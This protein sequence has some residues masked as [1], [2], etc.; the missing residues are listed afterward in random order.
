M[1]DNIIRHIL[2]Y[3]GTTRAVNH[4]LSG[5]GTPTGYEFIICV[6]LCGLTIAT[7][8]FVR[9]DEMFTKKKTTFARNLKRLLTSGNIVSEDLRDYRLDIN[10]LYR[11]TLIQS[12][13][14]SRVPNQRIIIARPLAVRMT[15]TSVAISVV[16]NAHGRR[17]YTSANRSK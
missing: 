9:F 4:L 14:T 15:R 1:Y 8:R 17:L 11:P 5:V 16:V 2:Y 6:T 7:G 10:I 12:R 13:K 3:T